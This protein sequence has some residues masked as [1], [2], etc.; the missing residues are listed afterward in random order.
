MKQEQNNPI[1]SI[2]NNQNSN[3][4]QQYNDLKKKIEN[5]K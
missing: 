3:L 4:K 2:E 5:L 1:N